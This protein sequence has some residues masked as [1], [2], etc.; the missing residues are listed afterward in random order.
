MLNFLS[1]LPIYPF[2][3]L[4]RLYNIHLSHSDWSLCPKVPILRFSLLLCPSDSIYDFFVCSIPLILY[5]F[6]YFFI[7]DEVV[8]NHISST[9][10]SKMVRA[11]HHFSALSESPS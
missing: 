7:F 4:L 11:W 6:Y 9:Q 1:F 3:S 10:C 8:Y 2:N 5:A